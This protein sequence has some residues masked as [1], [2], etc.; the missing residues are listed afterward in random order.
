MYGAGHGTALVHANPTHRH[1]F[2]A[3]PGHPADTSSIARHTSCRCGTHCSANVQ[4]GQKCAHHPVQLLDPRCRRTTHLCHANEPDFRL[5]GSGR[6]RLPLR[7]ID[8]THR[9]K[10]PN[11]ATMIYL[12]LFLTFF[13]IGLFGFGGGYGMISLIQSQVVVR[14]QWLSSAEFTNVL[15]ASQVTPGPIGINS[16]TY[17][18]YIAVQNAGYNEAMAILGSLTAT[19][20]L[21]L[22]SFI[23]MLIISRL[24]MKHMD[25]AVVQSIFSGIRPAVVGL[26]IAA[27]LI[28]MNRENFGTTA[29]PWQFYISIA[30]FLATFIGTKYIKIHPIKMILLCAFAGLMLL[31]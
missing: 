4:H 13:E 16:A 19:I 9:R 28:L 24:L 17:C 27:T 5:T 1:A 21:I 26:L 6:G 7:K 25:N 14:H 2:P 3:S 22:P 18:G 23:L 8:Q 15:A 30:L 31:Y 20:A 29:T 12:Y 11:R 10:Q